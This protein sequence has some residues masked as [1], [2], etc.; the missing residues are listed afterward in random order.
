LF[1]R[2]QVFQ[3]GRLALPGVIAR[4]LQLL[5]RVIG[6]DIALEVVNPPDLPEVRADAGM[7]EQVLLNL[8]VNARDAMPRGGRIVIAARALTVD[9]D[10]VRRVPQARLGRFVG[11]S[12]RD[13]GEGIAPDILPRIFDP[14][15]TT[16]KEGKGTGLGLAT[17][18]GI[19]EQHAGWIEVDSQPGRGTTFEVWFPAADKAT[20]PPMP[21]PALPVDTRGSETILVVEDKDAGR[22]VLQAVLERFGY[23]VVLAN[24]GPEALARWAEHKDRIDLLFTDVMMP[25]GLTGKDLANRLRADRPGL[26]VIFCSGYDAHILDASTLQAAGTRFLTKPFDVSRLTE[27]VRE[28]LDT[29]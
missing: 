10:Y 29:K 5:A 21:A 17:V 16:K 23:Q 25:G 18:Y 12:V 6:D 20:A 8:V 27:V 15:F 4:L 1:S 28:L 2:W 13:T 11:L 7:V 22:T 9:A 24:D 26:K 19:I 3:P 14:F